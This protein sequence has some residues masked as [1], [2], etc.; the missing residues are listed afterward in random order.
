MRTIQ[1]LSFSELLT[2]QARKK[3][4]VSYRIPQVERSVFWRLV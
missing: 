2:K 1:K 3:K 4:D